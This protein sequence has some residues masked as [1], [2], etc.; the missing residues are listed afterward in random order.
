MMGPIMTE[1]DVKALKWLTIILALLL[2]GVGFLLA[3]VFA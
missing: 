1:G 3:K 2:V